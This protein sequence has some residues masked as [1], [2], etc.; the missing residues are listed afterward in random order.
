M[1]LR[2]AGV[3][4]VRVSHTRLATI[5]WV[6]MRVWLRATWPISCV[7]DTRRRHE[8]WEVALQLAEQ[9]LYSFVYITDLDV[10]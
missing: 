5:M 6:D 7:V 8:E 4:P 3:A 2:Y 1:Y 10:N 9:L